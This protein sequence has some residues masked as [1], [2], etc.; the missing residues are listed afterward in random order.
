M[1]LDEG[2]EV[3][4]GCFV[5]LTRLSTDYFEYRTPRVRCNLK[6]KAFVSCI[7]I[8]S[9]TIVERVWTHC[10]I[11]NMVKSDRLMLFSYNTLPYDAFGHI[12]NM[13]WLYSVWYRFHYVS[14][15]G[16]TNYPPELKARE[17][18]SSGVVIGKCNTS[19]YE[20]DQLGYLLLL[21]T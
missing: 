13:S 14:D 11:L 12:F 9:Y 20:S 2:K 5:I 16:D 18:H 8:V 17:T 4:V 21:N 1:T 3:R 6:T 10:R 19:K 15:S 7:E